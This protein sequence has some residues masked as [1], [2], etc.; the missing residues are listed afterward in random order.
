MKRALVLI[1]LQFGAFK[2]IEVRTLIHTKFHTI[3]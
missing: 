3:V 1:F 2:F